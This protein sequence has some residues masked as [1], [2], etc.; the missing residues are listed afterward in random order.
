[1][2][3][4]EDMTNA[5]LKEECEERGIEVLA[6]NPTK[7]NKGEYLA[8]LANAE[9]YTTPVEDTVD[10]IVE[11]KKEVSDVPQPIRPVAKQS[12]SKL[13]R[14]DMLRKDRVIIHDN[15]ENQSKDK[16]ELYSVSWG[17]RLLNGQTDWVALDGKPQYVR[18]GAL[19]NLRDAMTTVHETDSKG[20]NPRQMRVPRFVIIPVKGLTPD[21][22][23][24]LANQQR[25][26]NSKHA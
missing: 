22:L 13:Q 11:V 26:R 9:S 24:A 15:Q 5:M 21:E 8:A 2:S 20:L 1:M 10:E 18:R 14:L 3:M 17:N 6:K 4:Y 16:D 25:M 19:G 23:E 12:R 7:P